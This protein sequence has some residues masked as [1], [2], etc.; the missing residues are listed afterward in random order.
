MVTASAAVTALGLMPGAAHAADN[1][2]LTTSTAGA[3]VGLTVDWTGPSSF[4]L[5]NVYLKDTGNDGES[6]YFY[7]SYPGWWDFKQRWNKNGYNT[8][9]SWVRLH[10]SIR[11]EIARLKVKVC[12]D[13]IRDNC[14]LSR[15]SDNPYVH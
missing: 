2:R 9:V 11:G 5:R 7:V 14:K 1:D 3:A 10:G 8:T 12:R 6:V 13:K 15:A 4:T